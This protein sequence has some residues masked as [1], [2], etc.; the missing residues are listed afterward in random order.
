MREYTDN[1]GVRWLVWIVMPSQLARESAATSLPGGL[2]G[3]WLCFQSDGQKRRLCPIPAGWEDRSDAE[4]DVLR[5][6]ADP[7]TGTVLA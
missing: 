3:G 7:V 2:Q 4:L 5:R 1:E 6:A